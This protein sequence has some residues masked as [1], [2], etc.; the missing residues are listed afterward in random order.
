MTL[1][2]CC[3]SRESNEPPSD[4]MRPPSNYP[5]TLRRPSLS[6]TSVS[7]KQSARISGES[8]AVSNRL[9]FNHLQI[10][11]DPYTYRLVHY[12]G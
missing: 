3:T 1:N 4:D 7:S 8:R 12:T 9:L 11:I 5:T 10:A 2:F 6:K